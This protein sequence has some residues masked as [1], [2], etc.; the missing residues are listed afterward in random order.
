MVLI[1]PPRG[2]IDYKKR[3]LV[4]IVLFSISAGTLFS[5]LEFASTLHW[6]PIEIT[7]NGVA[8]AAI[9]GG[10]VGGI[11]VP[12][13]APL[14]FKRD[15]R[16]ARPLV[17]FTTSIVIIIGGHVFHAIFWPAIISFIVTSLFVFMATPHYWEEPGLCHRCCY[18]LRGSLESNRCPECGTEFGYKP[19]FVKPV[20]ITNRNNPAIRIVAWLIRN[21]SL[22]FLVM[23]A[24][25]TSR[26]IFID[27]RHLNRTIVINASV[28]EAIRTESQIDLSQ[29]LTFN[30]D[31]V[32]IFGPYEGQE[33]IS[34]LHWPDAKHSNLRWQDNGDF[35]VFTNGNSAIEY[36]ILDNV[37]RFSPEVH[38]RPISKTTARFKTIADDNGNRKYLTLSQ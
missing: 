11:A 31:T 9:V 25:I 10:F 30:W 12:I 20:E 7:L 17:I 18:D 33:T 36:I 29:L 5:A 38:N 19:W 2:K 3:K 24:A 26:A 27:I 37:G 14:L 16:I 32:Y 6:Y 1:S 34:K 8:M 21:P 22:P 23:I 4:S 28:V 13:I 15:L 35:F